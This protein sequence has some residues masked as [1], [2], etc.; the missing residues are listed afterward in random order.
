MN[1]LRLQKS[2]LVSV[3][4][5][6]FLS[7]SPLFI[8]GCGASSSNLAANTQHVSIH[9]TLHGG[10]SPIYGSE[11]QL[12]AAGSPAAGGGYG[13]GAIALIPAKFVPFSDPAGN[14]NITGDYIIPPSASYFYIV[15]SG[16]S[17]G[18]SVPNQPAIN[19]ITT[20]GG[21][22]PTVGLSPTTTI[23]IN[24]VTTAAVAIA[25]Q[26]YFAPPSTLDLYTPSIGAPSTDVTGLANAYEEVNTLVNT[27]SGIVV[28]PSVNPN[29][30]TDN[31]LLLNTFGDILASCVNSAPGD[32]SCGNLF[33]AAS[34]SGLLQYQAAD[35]FQAAYYMATYPT[36][37]VNA[38]F[39]LIPERPPFQG[40][41]TAPSSFTVNVSNASTA[42]SA[43]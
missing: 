23:E 3:S 41:S 7:L 37:N 29:T 11:I 43:R 1:T 6:A 14:F 42:C 24:E 22:S 36:N 18:T 5:S 21:C 17:P 8:T 4:V 12:Y 25:L 27:S 20:L 26:S 40:Y 33:S 32:G 34:P 9:G 15:A 38:L 19:M 2:A 35:T 28:D 31:G 39:R 10:Q 16:G 13:Q 30:T